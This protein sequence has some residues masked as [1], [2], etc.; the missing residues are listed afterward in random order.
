MGYT[1]LSMIVTTY[2]SVILSCVLAL[3]AIAFY[4]LIERKFLGY[5]QT[6]KGPNK[7]SLIGIPVPFADAI[8][9]FTKE[10]STPTRSN[11]YLFHGAPILGLTLAILIW[12]LYPHAYQSFF[13]TF[14][15][16]YFLC[17]RSINVYS[18][19][20]AGWCSNSKY[21]LLGALRGVAQTI[22]YEVRITLV[23]IRALIIISSIDLTTITINQH[24]SIILIVPLITILWFITNLAETNRTPFDFAEGESEL[25]SGFNV[26]Y[27][28][29]VFALIFIAEYTRILAISI[30]T[31]SVIIGGL[32]F[33]FINN[34]ILI[35]E[36]L[37]I[38]I[39]YIWVRAT[40]P[41]MR[42]DHLI[43][44]TWKRFLPLSIGILIIITPI[45]YL[46]WYGAGWTD[47]SDDVN[48][49]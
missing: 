5:F 44:L 43:Y 45:V 33:I 19:F 42:Y 37:L 25:V 10:Q 32:T 6:R 8:K 35:R 29:G 26:E 16:L 12:A 47:N 48:Y 28:S 4:T 27:S 36:T 14:G 18:T 15:A 13:I 7:P 24:S 1:P 30:I 21:A 11:K 3:I 22:S 41:R 40:M 17:V 49:G 2:L 23:L 38:S 9:L 46:I 31:A 39:L 34:L 20:M